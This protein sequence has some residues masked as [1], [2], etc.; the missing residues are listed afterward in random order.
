MDS[1]LTVIED[2][3]GNAKASR[4]L[5]VVGIG[6]C[7]GAGKSTLAAALSGGSHSAQVVATD[8]FWDGSQFD[9]ERLRSD[10]L[11][12]VLGGETAFF[13]TWDWATRRAGPERQVDPHG[14][15]VIEGV[16]ALHEMFR[17]DEQVR[18]WVDAPADVRLARGVSRDGE[19]SRSM[20]TDVWMPNEDAYVRRDDPIICAQIIVDGTRPFL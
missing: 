4:S 17:S 5:V 7:G 13:E 10:V 1:P 9:L 20:W 6:G 11:D 12:V 16:C 3:I 14:V 18:V 8:S 2:L 19:A 15:V